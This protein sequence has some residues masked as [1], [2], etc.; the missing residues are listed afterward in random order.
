MGDVQEELTTLFYHII[1]QQE[2]TRNIEALFL[3]QIAKHVSDFY[4]Q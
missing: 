4:I 2:K 3:C 1:K